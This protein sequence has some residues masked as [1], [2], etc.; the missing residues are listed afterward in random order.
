MI[1][2]I[3]IG[4]MRKSLAISFIVASLSLVVS[5]QNL[6]QNPSFEYLPNWDSMWVLSLRKPSTR[7]AVATRIT[8][9]A[10]EG[11][12]SVELTNTDRDKWTY[13]YTDVINAPLS[14]VADRSYEVRGWIRSVEQGKEADLSVFWD[15][16]KKKQVIYTGI[17]DPVSMPD[18]FMVVGIITVDRDYNDG[19]LSLGFKSDKDADNN[20]VGSLLFDDFSVTLIPDGTETDIWA[21]SISEQISPEIIDHV[22]GTISIEVPFGTDINTLAPNN[23]MV[24]SGASISPAAGEPQDFSSPVVY[25]VTAQ[26]GIN[27]RDWT[28]TITV[29][30]LSTETVITSFSI[31]GLIAPATI[32][33]EVHLVLGR[34]SYGTD[35]SALVPSIGIS[36]GASI[37]PAPGASTDFSSP[38]IYTVTA[39]DGI[40]AQDW[41]VVI[42]IEPNRE[43]DITSFEI[44]E[45]IAPAIIDNSLHTV[46]ATVRFGTDLRFLIPSI[47]ASEG[48]VINPVS[49]VATDFS[50]PVIYTVTADD[51]ISMQNWIVTVTEGPPSSETDITTF[52]IPEL[53]AP[54]IIHS[55]VHLITGSLPYGTDLTALVPGIVVSDGAAIN[56]AS[57]AVTDF[58]TPVTYIV[59][60][61]DGTTFQVWLVNI[62][63]LP[64][65]ETDITGISLAEQTGAYRIIAVNHTVEIEVVMGTDVTSLGPTFSLSPGATINPASGV[66]R[67]FTNSLEYLVTAED[68]LTSQV[69]T[70]S[71]T[72]EQASS[73]AEITSFYIPELS[74]TATIDHSLHTVVGSV[75]YGTDLTALIPSIG[76]SRGASIDPA[77]EVVTDFS[78]PVNYTITAED[79]TTLQDWMVSIILDP[80]VGIG[81]SNDE[82]FQIY[83]NPATDFVYI[84]LTRETSIRLF[85]LMGKLCYSKDDVN[86]DLTIDVSDF[87][88]GVYIV[89]LVW[90]GGSP[91]QQEMILQ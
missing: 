78:S 29:L 4:S 8:S 18:W 36:R 20:P 5:G 28:V 32:H 52:N 51:G 90:E 91:Q 50:T 64:N 21:F 72:L 53:I 49:G 14:F 16:S 37:D 44:P 66:S 3:M 65:I 9:D 56:P 70:V 43:T 48:A 17:P 57:G 69:W 47:A 15:N 55:S 81:T 2:K 59:T 26:N 79:V 87:K 74:A 46:V 88:R 25:T 89:S 41:V 82:S 40:T 39:E 12:S 54:A 71:V 11:T 24:S 67:D 6:V 62:Q 23:I 31:P 33:N 86:G 77:S 38:V 63:V 84:K 13:F 34:V 61:E 85:D 1:G 83:P 76:I 35:V 30:P 73:E 22:Q 45:L 7:T 75:P 10:H 42:E 58:S 80:A 19:Y 68:G 27:T 60:A